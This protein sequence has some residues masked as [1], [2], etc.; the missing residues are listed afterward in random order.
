MGLQKKDLHDL[1]YHIFEID[2]YQSKMGSDKNIVTVSFSVNDK[3]PGEDLV[4]FIEKGYSF[5]LDADV[6]AGE[7]SDGTYKVFIELERSRDVVDQILEVVDGV[8]KLT[9][10]DDFK[11][12]YYKNFRS[13]PATQENLE[14]MIPTDPDSYGIKVNENNLDNYKNFFNRSYLEDIQMYDNILSIKKT[15][16]DPINFKFVDIDHKDNIIA[17]L[18]ETFNINSYPEV[19]FLTKYIGDYNI[20]KYGEDLLLENADKVLVV[21]RL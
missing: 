19:L 5:V 13:M 11:F 3:G 1:V 10:V 4:S 2:S 15:Y 14:E 9:G 12:R 6:T 20:S 18:N 21:R 17:N 16:A 8:S 7:Q